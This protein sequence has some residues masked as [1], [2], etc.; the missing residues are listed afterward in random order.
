MHC[1]LSFD[2]TLLLNNTLY[3]TCKCSVLYNFYKCGTEMQTSSIEVHEGDFA[4]H[5]HLSK[6]KHYSFFGGSMVTACRADW[7]RPHPDVS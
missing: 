4:L 6:K 7:G 3:F 1:S 2:R 5:A